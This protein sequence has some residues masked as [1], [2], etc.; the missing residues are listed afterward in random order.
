VEWSDSGKLLEKF[1]KLNCKK[2]YFYGEENKDTPAV[3][4]TGFAE[5]YMISNSGHGMM[6]DN[7]KEFYAKLAGFISSCG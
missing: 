5:Q 1:K 6:T 4:E 3:K 7:P 2:S